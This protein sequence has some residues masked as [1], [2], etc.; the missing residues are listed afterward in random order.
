[1]QRWLHRGGRRSGA[2]P[3]QFLLLQALRVGSTELRREHGT[4]KAGAGRRLQMVKRTHLSGKNMQ[5]VHKEDLGQ[6]GAEQS[7]LWGGNCDVS[8]EQYK[9]TFR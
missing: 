8:K 6:P 7:S 2:R 1:M 4:E 3:G 5:T 9:E